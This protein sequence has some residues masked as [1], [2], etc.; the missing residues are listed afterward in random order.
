MDGERFPAQHLEHE[1]GDHVAIG[2]EALQG[3][4]DVEVSKADD[5][6]GVQLGVS[7]AL[8]FR[9]QLRRAIG[10]VWFRRM[11]FPDRQMLQFA[12]DARGGGDHH[13]ADPVLARRL[14]HVDGPQHVHGGV[15]HR[16]I[17]RPLVA[18][19]RREV[20]DCVHAACGTVDRAGIRHVTDDQLRA[21]RHI[22]VIAGG[23]VVDDSHAGTAPQKTAR[24]VRTDESGAAG[25]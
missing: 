21:I 19:R 16:V 25:N 9:A 10:R 15:Q 6:H 8:L 3:A 18:D 7:K 24:N 4:K 17:Y 14:E 2:V 12:E 1:H 22:G 20:Q 13:F 5:V 23:E 11:V